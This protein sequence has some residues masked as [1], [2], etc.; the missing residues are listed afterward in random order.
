MEKTKIKSQKRIRR[1]NRIRAKVQGTTKRPRL[2]VFKSNRYVSAQII[3]DSKGVSLA[4]S[5][6]AKVSGKT[7]SDKAKNVGLDI[8]KKAQNKKIK[9]VIFDRGGYIYT[10]NI[11]ALAEGAREGGLRF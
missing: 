6:S 11:K 4:S 3:D 10:G 9:D 1:H 2:S 5:T 7:F 8:A